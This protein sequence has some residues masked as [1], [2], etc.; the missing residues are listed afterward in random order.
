[1]MTYLYCSALTVIS[2]K[3]Y[4]FGLNLRLKINSYELKYYFFGCFLNVKF[5][6]VVGPEKKIK[7]RK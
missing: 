1:M 2:L 5:T 7:G 3:K 6:V 4:I